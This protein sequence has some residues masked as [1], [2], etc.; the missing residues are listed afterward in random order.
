MLY[1]MLVIN[2]NNLLVDIYIK[3]YVLI[4]SNAR[5][6]CLGGFYLLAH[7]VVRY[8]CIAKAVCIILLLW[9]LFVLGLTVGKCSLSGLIILYVAS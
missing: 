8:T 2:I 7:I 9:S 1:L 5:Q 4:D 6:Y 3:L